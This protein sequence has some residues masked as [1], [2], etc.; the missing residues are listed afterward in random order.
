MYGVHRKLDVQENSLLFCFKM[1][2]ERGPGPKQNP[3]QNLVFCGKKWI[4]LGYH[5]IDD[6]LI[7]ETK[8]LCS[9]K[10]S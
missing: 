8:E 3:R 4:D 5:G 9:F 10:E 1:A 6:F 2:K 7:V